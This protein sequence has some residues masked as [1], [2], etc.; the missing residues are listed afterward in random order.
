VVTIY[1]SE[2]IAERRRYPRKPLNLKVKFELIDTS[3]LQSAPPTY[4]IKNISAG[5]LA[6]YSEHKL[7]KGQELSLVLYLPPKDKRS[8]NLT[9]VKWSE[10][11]SIPIH[12]HAQIAWCLSYSK[13]QY[14]YGVE[15]LEV[16]A[17]DQPD[18]DE[19]LKDFYLHKPSIINE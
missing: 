7:K 2:V 14:G 8:P 12:V 18:F 5:G 15:F 1:R 10:K 9:L 4:E 6:L 13:H 17:D 3:S 11:D 19:F 16:D